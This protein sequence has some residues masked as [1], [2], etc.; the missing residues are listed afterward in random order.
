MISR[1]QLAAVLALCFLLIFVFAAPLAGLPLQQ[2]AEALQQGKEISQLTVPTRPAAPL[3]TGEKGAQPSEITFVP[4]SR[5]VTAKFHVED[6]NGY[7]LPNLRRENFAVYEDGVRQKN[8]TVEIEHA[9]LSVA[10]VRG[11]GGR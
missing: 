2:T 10:L 11:V 1:S 8:V 7:F 9:P 3:Y 4:L 6:P 5:T